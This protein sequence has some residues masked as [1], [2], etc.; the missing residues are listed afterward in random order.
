MN[1]K[2]RKK[3]FRFTAPILALAGILL[4]GSGI[5]YADRDPWLEPFSQDS[6][7][8]TPIGSNADYQAQGYF[9]VSP[10]MYM[11]ADVELKFKAKATDPI[12]TIY[13]PNS[14]TN[15]CAGTNDPQGT[16]YVPDDAIV[17]DAIT[18]GGIY[19][20]P[21]AVTGILQPDGHT[22]V[23]LE[24]MCRNVEGG[25][26]YGYRY[27]PDQDIFQKGING[28]HWGSGLSGF[29]GSIR[30]GELT[31]SNSIK[32]A[33]KF[34]VWG[35]YLYYNAKDTTPGYRWPADRADSGA[36]TQ[37]HGTDPRFK[38]GALLAIPPST[39]AEQ[40]GLKTQ[41]GLKL[42]KALQDYGAYIADDTGWDSYGWDMDKN[43]YGE[44]QEKF[45]YG[46]D[47]GSGSTGSAGDWY[48]DNVALIKALA[49]IN[50]NSPTSVGGGGTP[51]VSLADPNFG[52]TDEIAPTAPG[53][54]VLS[55]KTT[56]SVTLS[57]APSTD[58]NAIMEYDIY[59]NGKKVGE[60]YGKT[61]FTVK[62]LAK[63]TE[64]TFKV[65]ALDTGLNPST[66]SNEITVRTFDGY[67]NNFND[68]TAQGWSLSS[69]S[70]LEYGHLKMTN[71][72]GSATA[73][74]D[75][76][77][78]AIQGGY[79]KYSIKFQSIA[80]DNNGKSR[81]YFNYQDT[82]NTYYVEIGGG[83][84]NTITLNKRT[85][86]V[87]KTLATSA[88]SFPINNWDWP[89]IEIKYESGGIISVTG[90]RGSTRTTLINPV[91]DTTFTSGKVGVA[92]L[93]TESLAD[94]VSVLMDSP[95]TDPDVTPPPVP[96]NLTSPSQTYNSII[97]NWRGTTDVSG[98]AEYQI[99]RD[100]TLIGT[101]LNTTF[102]AGSLTPATT[103]SFTI[104][105]KDGA[106][107]V[108]A[109]TAPLT[110]RTTDILVN[111]QYAINFDDGQAIGWVLNSASVSNKKLQ[112]GNWN[113]AS[114]AYY[115]AGKFSGSYVYKADVSGNGSDKSN[116]LRMFF[117]YTNDQNTYLI[118]AGG[119]ASS[120][121]QLKKVVGGTETVLGTY[122]AYL[123]QL[124][125]TIE[126]RYNQGSITV[127][128]K[129]GDTY[130]TLFDRVVDKS[131]TEG[132]IG[133][134]AQWNY[135]YFDNISV[136]ILTPVQD[137]TPPTAP[138]Y[139]TVANQGLTTADL[140]WTASTDEV[141]VSGYSI[142]RNGQYLASVNGSQKTYKVTGLS[143]ATNYTFTVK[144]L[145]DAGNVSEASN[146][147]S[148]T[149]DSVP[150]NQPYANN[151]NSG[152]I[153]SWILDSSSTVQYNSLQL[154][155]W[156]G[157][158]EAIYKGSLY[159]NSYSIQVD[160]SAWGTGQYN[161]TRLLFGYK[162][163][164][165]TYVLEGGGQATDPVV[166]KKLVNG[167]ET[168]LGSYRS[169]YDVKNGATLKVK[170]ATGTITVTGIKNGLETVLISGV[171]DNTYP[172]G[173]VGFGAQYNYAFFDNFT[174]GGFADVTPPT[175]PA[176]LVSTAQT[177]KS[178][179]LAWDAST[180]DNGTVTYEVYR[181]GALTATA[182]EPKATISGLSEGTLY[183]FTVLARDAAGNASAASIELAVGTKDT[184]PPVTTVQIDPA[185]PNGTNGWYVSNVTMTLSATDNVSVTS[186]TYRINGG[187][188]T[189]YSGG[190]V[191]A[192]LADGVY[193]VDYYSTDTS[194]NMEAVQS[195]T[196]QLDRTLPT[197]AVTVD[198]PVLWSPNNKLISV[199]VK[200][201]PTDAAS[202][203]KSYVLTSIT[204]NESSMNP[205]TDIVGANYGTGDTDFQLLAAR[206]GSGTGRIYT[207]IYTVTDM[208]GYTTNV[209]VQVTVPHDRGA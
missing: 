8:N 27:T 83:S 132:T 144:A 207:I 141:G 163:S 140:T 100:G 85:A 135:A 46:F 164:K 58:N 154:G 22:L 59:N 203:I 73:I 194:G 111:Q 104:K 162:D 168:V 165:N 11:A 192:G 109:A 198:K 75:N 114:S 38:M 52:P 123:L 157:A 74:Y 107:N 206:D 148:V 191:L 110:I 55:D 21:N 197:A 15:R 40:L 80:A 159:A 112:T 137:T 53:S 101:T 47:A 14:W 79:Y 71:W 116:F 209:S 28:T 152:N 134:G 179:D 180:D 44:F 196:I 118:E 136:S 175:V 43:A 68:N 33:I 99:Y 90:V 133:G 176:H 117:N 149:T 113:G 82:D 26:V 188:W 182:T 172:D 18:T 121:V 103:Y 13:A 98:I 173:Y 184:T 150:V 146:T 130:T 153:A 2:K 106:G 171:K 127:I 81:A 39:T 9:P 185:A 96:V 200:V 65:K 178:I 1:D 91:T 181:D 125:A 145:D 93:N 167:S 129:M 170:V 31:G 12:R 66:Y 89:T 56:N 23:Q 190:N 177:G 32:H 139:L 161:V 155:N 69:N 67:F 205:S 17:D 156:G 24:P 62:G 131:L 122:N 187:A 49:I 124:G 5:A 41:A 186:T 76:R 102:T 92:A 16:M 87:T 7:W 34:N 95:N 199:G 138:S 60:T 174:I 193:Q 29:G 45:G 10:N 119:G 160:V 64:Y 42:F 51:R 97:L 126:I 204:A 142:Y 77:L 25:P 94:D 35:N 20:T 151:F 166:L 19:Y 169:G 128:G 63:N 37:Y 36:P 120:S 78:F 201:N 30:F 189:S 183:H 3:I 72:G 6:I 147:A 88:V 84:T 143:P 195:N 202:G 57:W 105:A 48:K 50:N 115:A 54:L 86:G 61:S 158:A 4:A 70:T 108:S 208:A